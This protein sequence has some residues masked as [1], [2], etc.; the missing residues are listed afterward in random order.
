MET[1]HYLRQDP[2]EWH[3]FF[4]LGTDQIYCFEWHHIFY[5]GHRFLKKTFIRLIKLIMTSF[6]PFLNVHTLV[7]PPF[8]SHT[9]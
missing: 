4:V 7:F 5:I 8:T 2:F 3:H 9:F 1:I 6:G